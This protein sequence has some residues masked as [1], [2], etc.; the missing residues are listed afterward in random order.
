V[1]R[2]TESRIGAARH[3]A[4]LAKATLVGVGAVTFIA[5]AALSRVAFP[6]HSKRSITPLSPPGQFVEVVRQN[7][8]E[9]GMLAPAQAD[10]SVATAQT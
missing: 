3:R 5:A 4:S 2:E 10:P 6:G 1:A 7:Q 8:L 9:S